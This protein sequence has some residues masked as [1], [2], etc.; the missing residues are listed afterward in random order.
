MK[1]Y[2]AKLVVE[3]VKE[4]MLR[5]SVDDLVKDFS[6]SHAPYGIEVYY[7]ENEKCFMACYRES[8]METSVCDKDS[9]ELAMRGLILKVLEKDL[10]RNDC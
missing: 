1:S 10:T 8:K 3:A 4:K 6:L 5:Q 2:A 7:S 9:L